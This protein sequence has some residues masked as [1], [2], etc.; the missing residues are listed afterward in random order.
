MHSIII[1][2]K[3]IAVTLGITCPPLEP[4]ANGRVIMGGS[5]LGATAKYKCNHGFIL[6]G[7]GLNIRICKV[8]QEWS[9]YV[10]VCKR[11]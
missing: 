7:G 11:T 6:S 3:Y 4:I 5:G 9:G 1:M 10:G 2:I 8:N